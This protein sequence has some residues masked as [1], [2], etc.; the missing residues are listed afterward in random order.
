MMI[1]SGDSKNYKFYYFTKINPQHYRMH[2]YICYG[3]G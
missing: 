2:D 1:Y 3:L